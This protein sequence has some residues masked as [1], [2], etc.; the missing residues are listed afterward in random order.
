VCSKGRACPLCLG[1]KFLAVLLTSIKDVKAMQQTRANPLLLLTQPGTYSIVAMAVHRLQGNKFITSFFSGKSPAKMFRLA[2]QG[3]PSSWELWPDVLNPFSE[4][5]LDH[6]LIRLAAETSTNPRRRERLSV[7]ILV[8]LA[9]MDNLSPAL[10]GTSRVFLPSKRKI[11]NA[12]EFE[13]G[14]LFGF[15]E[16]AMDMRVGVQGILKAVEALKQENDESLRIPEVFAS[17]LCG[18]SPRKLFQ[19]EGP[20]GMERTN[21]TQ[22]VNPSLLQQSPHHPTTD[23]EMVVCSQLS[24]SS[25]SIA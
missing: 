3:A 21:S 14:D 8:V 24:L 7:V 10:P 18:G 22:L 11:S 17:T 23:D 9:I 2:T 1:D 15:I 16:K 19:E 12:G 4:S 6:L 13:V 20:G 5:N 25:R